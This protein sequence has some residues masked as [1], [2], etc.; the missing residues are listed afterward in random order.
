MFEKRISAKERVRNNLVKKLAEQDAAGWGEAHP[1][2]GNKIILGNKTY[3]VR[4]DGSYV[5]S[6]KNEAPT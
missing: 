1:E 5:R 3:T 6:K 4:H 2:T